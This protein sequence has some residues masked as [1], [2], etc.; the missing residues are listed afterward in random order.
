MM[1]KKLLYVMSFVLV[2]AVTGTASADTWYLPVP[3]PGFE[4]HVMTNFYD[5]VYINSDSYT[6]AWSAVLPEAQGAW[7]GWDYWYPG[8]SWPPLSGTSLCYGGEAAPDYIYQILD[9]IYVEGA[10]YTFEAWIAI[11]WSGYANNFRIFF[12]EEDYNINLAETSGKLNPA[13]KWL[14]KSVSYTATAADAGKKIGIKMYG[15][16]YVTFD[17][18]TL[19][20]DGPGLMNLSPA[21]GAVDV[22]VDENLVWIHGD[23][24]FTQEEVYFGTDPCALPLVATIAPPTLE[25]DPGDPNLIAS[26]TYYWYIVGTDS[27]MKKWSSPVWSFTTV[28][29]EAQPDYP[30]DGAVIPGSPLGDDIYTTLT[31]YPGATTVKFT[32]YFSEDYAEVSGRAQDANLGDPPYDDFMYYAGL[33]AVPPA[34]DS[35]VRGTVYYWTVDG[36]DVVGNV[37]PGEIWEFTI[38]PLYA[39]APS[40]P[41]DATFVPSDVL[42]SWKP[43]A[44]VTEHDIYFGTEYE[45]VRDARYDFNEPGGTAYVGPDEYLISRSEPN[46]MLT[47]LPYL[48]KRYW[49][50]DEVNGRLPPPLGGGTYYIGPVWNFTTIAEGVGTIREDLWWNVA[51]GG[52]DSLYN[53]PR[54]PANPDV[55]QEITMLDS[56][57]GLG[58]NYGGMIHGWLHPQKSG[59]YRFWI[60]AD[61]YCEL[62]LSTDDQPANMSRI[63]SAPG[64][65]NRYEWEWYASQKSALIP[66]V[67]MQKYYIRACWKEGTG[68][69]HCEVAWQGPDQP[70]AP[71][72]GLP[73]AVIPGSRLSPFAQLWAHTPNPR[74]GQGGVPSPVTLKWG[75]GNYAA[76]HDV[77]LSTSKALVEAR[78]AGAFMGRIDPN[79]FGP[80]PL[81]TG[82]FYYWAID[83]VND[84]GPDPGIWYG[85]TWMFRAEGA[86]G[87]LQGL[88]YHWDSTTLPPTTPGNV[89]PDPGPE[90]PFQIFVLSRIDPS[91]D[92]NWGSG[93]IPGTHSPDPLINVDYFAIKWVGHVECPVDADYTFYTTTD[94]GARLFINGVQILPIAAWQQQGMTEWSGSVVLSAGL[95]DIEMHYEEGNGGAGAQLRWSAIPSNPADDAINKQIIPAVYLWP[96]LFAAGPNPPH[97]A[98]IDE[99]KPALEWISGL[100]A[101][102]H[103]LYFSASFDDVNDRNPAVKQVLTDPCRLPAVTPLELG[104]T[105]YWCVDEVKTLAERWDARSVW[106]FTI[107]E[108]ISLDNFEDYND[109]GE[110]RVV[111]EDG[112]ANVV[113]GGTYPYQYV[114]QSGSSGSNLNLSSAVGTPTGGTG[115]VRPT[116]LN[117]DAMVLRYDNDGWTYTGLP[118]A[119]KWVYDAPYFSEIE[120]DTVGAGSLDVGVDWSGEGV[121]ALTLW[122]QGHPLS[123]GSYD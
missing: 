79:S 120:A 5:Y 105:Y 63:A 22:S 40:P 32:G 118:G 88:Y 107:N 85:S 93:A 3:D 21:N 2:L 101:L 4:D 86:A 67:G 16:I 94:D 117:Y 115:P 53:D 34:T 6:G 122:F 78:D 55:T 33:Y 103:E 91:V 90:N 116:P 69:D 7:I 29:G 89:P 45:A 111:W 38:Q 104:R 39:Y 65:L 14:H 95:H 52:I 112:Y 15:D 27:S 121:K 35:L 80:Y 47:G 97:L 19:L 60:A 50:V 44:G 102:T 51:A 25:Y 62:F 20:Y 30:Y 18:I 48:V 68:G 73:D 42:L 58:D 84:L 87:G 8:D 98:T 13:S 9:E 74:N 82:E 109:R 66:L 110:L 31:F 96:T 77:Y 12:T 46:Y 26:T 76:K 92:F 75:P 71:E 10:E 28:S 59:D 36:E 123:D 23:S 100:Y 64:W 83:E 17:E 113:W 43:G 49:R 61:D 99:R 70:I 119:E 24:T 54:F 56:G 37:F 11:P 108:C 81:A 106:E 1:S 57:T 72:Y 114:V 41:N